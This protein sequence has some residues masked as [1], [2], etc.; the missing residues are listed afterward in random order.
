MQFIRQL[1]I[2]AR[3]TYTLSIFMARVES[4]Y[5]PEAPQATHQTVGSQH[6]RLRYRIFYVFRLRP[7]SPISVPII[8]LSPPYLMKIS[9]PIF[10]CRNVKIQEQGNLIMTSCLGSGVFGTF[11]T[12]EDTVCPFVNL[13]DKVAP[14]TS[15]LS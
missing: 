3:I 5:L 6:K 10:F 15:S 7:N 1:S 8:I 11:L 4:V 13:I 12:A 2:F 9:S 14:G